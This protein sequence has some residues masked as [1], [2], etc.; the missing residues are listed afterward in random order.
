MRTATTPAGGVDP[1]GSRRGWPLPGSWLLLGVLLAGLFAMHG[2]GTHG[3]HTAHTDGPVPMAGM[4]THDAVAGVDA[5]PSHA[6]TT[7]ADHADGA[8]HATTGAASS[9]GAHLGASFGDLSAAAEADVSTTF[10][11]M[12]GLLG[13]CFAVLTAL[14]VWLLARV[15]TRPLATVQPGALLVAAPRILGRD[16]DPPSL[17]VLSVHRC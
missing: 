4:P 16:P 13:L 11:G 17:T 10:A 14:T 5:D 7:V 3:T 9:L 8:T 2:L 1:V 6:M 12:S 15:R